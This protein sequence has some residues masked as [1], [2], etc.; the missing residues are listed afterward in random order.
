MAAP[1]APTWLLVRQQMLIANVPSKL[2][3]RAVAKIPL[4][5]CNN[6]SCSLHYL[7]TARCN[8]FNNFSVKF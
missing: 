8:R 6:A 3:G 2:R 5:S 4:R 7:L 1:F